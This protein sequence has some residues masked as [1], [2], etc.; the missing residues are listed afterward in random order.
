MG[1][2]LGTQ[3]HM[4]CTVSKEC[5]L[6]M[7]A[8][9]FTRYEI[10]HQLLYTMLAEQVSPIHQFHMKK[11]SKAEFIN[12]HTFYSTFYDSSS[13]C[14][15][16]CCIDSRGLL[17]CSVLLLFS[18]HCRIVKTHANMWCLKTQQRPR[19]RP[20]IRF[21][22]SL[23]SHFHFLIISDADKNESSKHYAKLLTGI[24]WNS[25]ILQKYLVVNLTMR[26]KQDVLYRFLLYYNSFCHTLFMVCCSDNTVL[27][28]FIIDRMFWRAEV[29]IAAICKSFNFCGA[30]TGR[31][32]FEY[33]Y[34]DE[35]KWDTDKWHHHQA[36]RRSI[37]W[38]R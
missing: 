11:Y 6:I 34:R 8:Q 12:L 17:L 37:S 4:K 5:I 15:L 13:S 30:T 33:L 27:E 18:V 32:L 35:W 38:A 2:L 23:C 29:G 16:L 14:A 10:T 28:F 24:R 20:A 21:G 19:P 3:T 26:C 36:T 9:G 22:Q 7:S 1:E 31:I 25:A